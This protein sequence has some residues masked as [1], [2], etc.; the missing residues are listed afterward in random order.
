MAGDFIITPSMATGFCMFHTI[1]YVG[2][3]YLSPSTRPRRPINPSD[4][5]RHEDPNYIRLRI[6]AV[7][8]ATIFSVFVTLGAIKY[9]TGTTLFQ[10]GTLMGLW[11]VN[12]LWSWAGECG[13]V[14][15]LVGW[16]FIGSLWEKF[17]VSEGWRAEE[18]R[19]D[20]QWL[21]E[22]SGWRNL[23]AGPVTEEFV[24]RAAMVPLQILAGKKFSWIVWTTPLFFG[25]GEI[26]FL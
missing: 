2:I 19:S 7:T 21:N 20:W 6:R 14:L 13:R 1:L 23:V 12:G 9:A 26:Y 18:L 25:I 17:V 5:Y 10:A 4:A 15:L 8:F 3:L 11:P 16:L 22:W 24:F